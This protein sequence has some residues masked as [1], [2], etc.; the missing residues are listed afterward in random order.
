MVVAN[1]RGCVV[2]GECDCVTVHDSEWEAE[3]V[4][5]GLMKPGLNDRG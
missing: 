1:V 4:T 5:Y 2:V 3:L